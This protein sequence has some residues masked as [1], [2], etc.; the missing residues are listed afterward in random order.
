MRFATCKAELSV[1]PGLTWRDAECNGR[2]GRRRWKSESPGTTSANSRRHVKPP[3]RRTI[4]VGLSSLNEVNDNDVPDE[5]AS[6]GEAMVNNVKTKVY[7]RDGSVLAPNLVEIRC[8]ISIS[9]KK[10]R[11]REFSAKCVVLV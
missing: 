9:L 10:L 4:V 6:E 3:W 2:S 5:S 7:G 8:E 1:V 11:R